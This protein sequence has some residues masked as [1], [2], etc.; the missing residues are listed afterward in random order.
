MK[1]VRWSHLKHIGRS[2]LHYKYALDN[3]VDETPAMRI[4]S[5]AHSMTL[6]GW[7]KFDVYDGIR[8]GKEWEKFRDSLDGDVTILNAKEAATARA[9]SQSIQTNPTACELLSGETEKSIA[10][11]VNGR[12]CVGTPDALTLKACDL[13]DLKITADAN[14]DRFMWHAMKQGWIAQLVW[15]KDGLLALG[16]NVGNLFI[17][18]VE[19]KPP[20]PVVV[21]QLSERAEEQGRKTWRLLFERLMVHE[22]SDTWPGYSQS[23]VLL[24]TP[25]EFSLQ[26]DGE[27]VEA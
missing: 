7:R 11:E 22:A 26:I 18:A 6:G 14:P 9:V 4:G 20:H 3:G 10:W 15:Y 23:V 27:E 24:D 16:R 8:R 2:P 13:S 1:P 19:A 12:M 21:Y 5:A 25:E 17:V